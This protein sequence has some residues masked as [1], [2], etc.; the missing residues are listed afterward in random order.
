MASASV[1]FERCIGVVGD[2]S[3]REEL[4]LEGVRMLSGSESGQLPWAM[5][6]EGRIWGGL[7]L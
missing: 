3:E 7:L 2:A 1:G 5:G 6:L 4:L